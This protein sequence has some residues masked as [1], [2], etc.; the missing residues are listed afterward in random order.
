LLKSL[1][2]LARGS[3]SRDRYPAAEAQ[4]RF[5]FTAIIREEVAMVVRVVAATGVFRPQQEYGHFE[6]WTEAQAFAALLNHLN[7]IE[8]VE[9]QQIVVSATLASRCMDQK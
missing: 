9:A 3:K 7:G 6:T 4:E 1:T 2:H 5:A 8:L